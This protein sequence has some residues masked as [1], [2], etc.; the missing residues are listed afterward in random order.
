MNTP[1]EEHAV[2]EQFPEITV[3]E[4]GRGLLVPLDD[5]NRWKLRYSRSGDNLASIL[6]D[7]H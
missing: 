5:Q 7:E 4:T 6:D 2:R 1:R 3:T